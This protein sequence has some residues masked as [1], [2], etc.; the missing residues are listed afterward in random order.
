VG[1]WRKGIVLY[2]A[3]YRSYVHLVLGCTPGFTLKFTFP[4]QDGK[5]EDE[6]SRKNGRGRERKG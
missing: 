4:V 5:A 3:H 2:L 1:W 6:K